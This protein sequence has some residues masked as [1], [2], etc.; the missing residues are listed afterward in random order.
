MLRLQLAGF[1]FD[2]GR[3][4]SILGKSLDGVDVYDRVRCFVM[5]LCF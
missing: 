3:P 1:R 2:D 5:F 4:M